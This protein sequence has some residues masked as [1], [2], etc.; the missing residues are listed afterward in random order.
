MRSLLSWEL[1]ARLG[2]VNRSTDVS[3]LGL[4][5]VIKT[6]V[7]HSRVDIAVFD[8][9]Q[10]HFSGSRFL[11]PDFEVFGFLLGF[12]S[13]LLFSFSSNEHFLVVGWSEW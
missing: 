13:L 6:F 11:V 10:R 8:F 7:H 2:D 3:P 12:F 9:L 5:E 1:H 4:V